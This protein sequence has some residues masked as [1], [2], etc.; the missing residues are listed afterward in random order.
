M[1]LITGAGHLSPEIAR[2]CPKKESDP[3]ALGV[4][5]IKIELSLNAHFPAARLE[6]SGYGEK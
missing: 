2:W 1:A 6:Q 4:P 3:V 5:P